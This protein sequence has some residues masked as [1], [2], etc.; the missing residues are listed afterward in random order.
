MLRLP[1]YLQRHPRSGIFYFR[2]AIPQA[3]ITHLFYGISGK[4]SDLSQVKQVQ[5][6]TVLKNTGHE[7]I[8]F[9]PHIFLNNI[10]L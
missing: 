5:T 4:D 9:M 3:L 10:L 1:S 6:T 8:L 2:I 7:S